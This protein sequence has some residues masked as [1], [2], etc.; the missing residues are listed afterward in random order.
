[1]V[2]NPP[3][4]QA[5]LSMGFSRQE[6]WSGLPFPSPGDLPDP[7]MRTPFTSRPGIL[8]LGQRGWLGWL[9]I[10]LQSK[11]P[12]FDLWVGKIPWRRKWHPTPV[13]LPGKSHGQRGL[14]GYS[15]Q[16]LKESDTTERLHF[17]SLSLSIL[18]VNLFG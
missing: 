9:R 5:P 4:H 6:Y 11:R 7:G 16:G 10:C 12:G 17:L 14:V 3:T 1:M 8:K 2:K 13:I 15:P 18:L